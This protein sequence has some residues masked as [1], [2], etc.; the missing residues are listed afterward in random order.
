MKSVRWLASYVL[1]ACLG[2]GA[3]FFASMKFM[4]PAY[5]QSAPP[6]AAD[7]PPE[8][9]KDLENTQ[10]PP[11]ATPPSAPVVDIPSDQPGT[12]LSEPSPMDMPPMDMPPSM[13]PPGADFPSALLPSSSDGYFYDPT[14]KR[15]PFRPFRD[16][17][18][19]QGTGGSAAMTLEPLQR[20]EL[21]RLQIVGILWE[22]RTPRAMVR[23]PDGSVYTIVKN[24]KIGRNEGYVAAIREGEVVVV[25]TVYVDGVS[26]KETKVM[27]FRK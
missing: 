26:T 8:V 9:I 4:A 22:V 1:V 13:T 3:A 23:D 7:I 6:D 27:E 5:S 12:P 10:S 14:G 15:D 16:I 19:Q 2:L 17:R 21:D 24:S 11:T 20:W 25:E 18:P